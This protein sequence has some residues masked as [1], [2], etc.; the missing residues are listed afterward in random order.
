MKSIFFKVLLLLLLIVVLF[1]LFEKFA[2]ISYEFSFLWLGSYFFW[3]AVRGIC[4]SIINGTVLPLFLLIPLFVMLLCAYRCFLNP[5]AKRLWIILA[6]LIAWGIMVLL[7]FIWFMATC[8][9]EECL[10]VVVALPFAILSFIVLLVVGFLFYS[11]AKNP[12]SRFFKNFI[13]IINVTTAV[14][15]IIFGVFVVALPVNALFNKSNTD[16]DVEYTAS[17]EG[18]DVCKYHYNP[19]KCLI[20]VA[21]DISQDESGLKKDPFLFCD[22]LEDTKSKAD[23]YYLLTQDQAQREYSLLSYSITDS[24]YSDVYGSCMYSSGEFDSCFREGAIKLLG[25]VDYKSEIKEFVDLENEFKVESLAVCEKFNNDP[26]GQKV[27]SDKLFND[28][29]QWR[30]NWDKEFES[31]QGAYHIQDTIN[32]VINSTDI[33]PKKVKVSR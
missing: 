24:L 5:A 4:H 1:A 22:A 31:T 10:G 19:E 2:Y 29:L 3:D 28:Y 14:L 9:G 16:W 6:G 12:E 33:P 13:K 30:S 15:L 27:C 25:D 26:S 8:S 21:L 7:P 18:P 17:K 23:C 20:D 11:A 32:T